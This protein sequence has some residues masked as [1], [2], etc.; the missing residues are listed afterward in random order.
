MQAEAFL[1]LLEGW[2]REAAG[3]ALPLWEELPGLSA[4]ETG[5]PQISPDNYPAA[6]R[7]V[8]SPWPD[9]PSGAALPVSAALTAPSFPDF[10][11]RS[12]FSAGEGLE[13]AVFSASFPTFTP[14]EG[15]TAAVSPDWPAFS[16]TELP[17]FP[18]F[19]PLERGEGGEMPALRA[20]S[21]PAEAVFSLSDPAG[22]APGLPA[23][24]LPAPGLPAPGLPALSLPALSLPALWAVPAAVPAAGAVEVPALST[25]GKSPRRP[26]DPQLTE[27]P[28]QQ[29][30]PAALSAALTVDDLLSQLEQR[31]MQEWQGSCRSRF[32]P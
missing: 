2:F 27:E 32:I 3:T 8:E 21:G 6:T 15:L 11:G 9:G 22:A 1:S 13:Q 24:G 23:P 14:M 26:P 5:I 18:T 29:A 7:P 17:N 12:G 10:T 19:P 20:A 31:L 30:E 16:G 25:G 4:G 28:A